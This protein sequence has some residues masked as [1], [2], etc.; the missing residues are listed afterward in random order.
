MKSIERDSKHCTRKYHTT[1]SDSG[2]CD[3]PELHIEQIGLSI[4][5]R[6]TATSAELIVCPLVRIF[7]VK[8]WLVP[9]LNPRLNRQYVQYQLKVGPY[10][11]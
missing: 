5:V 11:C 10:Q 4:N 9:V 8:L 2:L 1:H 7:L 3:D 6:K